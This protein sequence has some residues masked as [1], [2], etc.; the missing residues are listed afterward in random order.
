MESQK[1]NEQAVTV[2]VYGDTGTGKTTWGLQFAI[3]HA[4]DRGLPLLCIDSFGAR[5]FDGWTACRAGG[6]ASLVRRLYGECRNACWT[7]TAPEEV[8]AIARVLQE[9]GK[10][11]RPVVVLIDE[12]SPWL[13]AYSRPN[14]LLL[15]VRS[16]RHSAVSIISTTQ[17]LGDVPPIYLQC[18]SVSV[19]FR[20]TSPRALQRIADTYPSVPIETVR[21]LPV[22]SFVRIGRGV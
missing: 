22:G 4:H 3:A 5:N 20:N 12:T 2:G 10:R 17:Y 8:C 9:M 16:Y 14:E 15:L 18:Q 21:T 19:F 13:S 11:G 6:G 1:N 7:P